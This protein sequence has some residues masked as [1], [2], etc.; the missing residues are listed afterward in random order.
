MNAALKST[1]LTH[2][3]EEPLAVINEAW[4]TNLSLET[5]DTLTEALCQAMASLSLLQ[6]AQGE[7][8]ENSKSDLTLGASLR[9]SC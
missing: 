6:S 7:S 8:E 3:S 4:G 5:F 1:A 9:I 2:G